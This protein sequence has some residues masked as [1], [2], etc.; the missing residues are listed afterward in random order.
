MHPNVHN[1]IICNNQDMEATQVLINR[2]LVSD[3]VQIYNG[4][5]LGHT[6]E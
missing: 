5:L 2:W 3:V 1:I 6:K 4:I